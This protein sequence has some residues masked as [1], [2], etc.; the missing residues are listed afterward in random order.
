[1][2]FGALGELAHSLFLARQIQRL[3]RFRQ[4]QTGMLLNGAR[5]NRH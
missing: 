5:S 3:F 1:M 4:Q 2:K